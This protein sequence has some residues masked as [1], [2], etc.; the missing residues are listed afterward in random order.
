[1]I[2]HL[3]RFVPIAEK[4]V[5]RKTSLPILTNICIHKGKIIANDLETTAIMKISDKRSYLLPFGIVNTIL[6]TKPQT[7]DVELLDNDFIKIHYDNKSVRFKMPETVEDYPLIEKKQFLQIGAW[8]REVFQQLFQQLPFCSTDELRQS[9]LGVFIRQNGTLSCCATS[10]HILRQVKN[11]N[12]D[13]KCRFICNFE[14]ILSRKCIQILAKH[15]VGNI[16]VA[17]HNDTLI[18]FDL[19]SGLQIIDKLIEGQYP[20][21]ENVIPNEFS[22]NVKFER[23][24][25]IKLA[26]EAKPFVNRTNHLAVL[27]VQHDESQLYAYDADMETT[28]QSPLPMQNKSG[29][30]IEIGFN[31]GL[32]EQVIKTIP[33]KEIVWS[34]TD[35][36]SASV[37]AG[38][39]GTAVNELYLIMPIRLDDQDKGVHDES[40]CDN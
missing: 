25:W 30:N 33:D 16:K 35:P 18:R 14:G 1:M 26:S 28:W 7:I 20:K 9:L 38:T 17:V 40:Q 27:D 3:A 23:K 21:V 31:L 6:K 2:H 19:G 36:A 29:D 32:F 11:L 5:P 10:G 4:I 37:M 8:T 15:A 39:N 12:P 13:D 22:G 24:D 34:Y